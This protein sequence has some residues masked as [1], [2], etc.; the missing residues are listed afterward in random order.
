MNACALSLSHTLSQ[1]VYYDLYV[2]N[3]S[4]HGQNHDCRPGC[5]RRPWQ[6]VYNQ[7]N[8]RNVTR[9]WTKSGKF[10]AL[11]HRHFLPPSS[12]HPV[13]HYSKNLAIHGLYFLYF[14]YRFYTV[15]R[16]QVKFADDWMQTLD[17]GLRS[18]C[19]TN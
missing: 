17:L 16:N 14:Q 8:Q 4:H 7:L 9:I 18:D 5:P 6:V 3:I 13:R 15:D 12:G 11:P 19:S 10:W 2:C 1:C